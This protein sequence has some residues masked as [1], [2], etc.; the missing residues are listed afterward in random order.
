MQTDR[1]VLRDAAEVLSSAGLRASIVVRDLGSGRQLSIA[2]DDAYPLA[3]VVKLPLALAVL[4]CIDEGRLDPARP[5]TLRPDDRT[6]GLVGYCRFQHPT[7]VSVEDLLYMA[8]CLSDDT[9]ADA[10]FDLCPP[11]AVTAS[12]R[13]TGIAGITV[14]HSIRE[15][16]RTLAS[17]LPPEQMPQALALAIRAS[18]RGGGH[19]IPQLDVSSANAGTANACVE[20]LDRIWRSPALDGQKDRLRSLLAMNVVRQRLAPDLESDDAVWH[21]KTGTFLHLRHEIG[22]LEHADGRAIAIAV[23]SESSVP[24]QRQPA[25]EQALGLA[26]KLLHDR[27]RSAAA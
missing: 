21:S 17:V 2:A 19:L 5:V 11:A 14:R 16:H 9:A 15:L 26:A 8:V 3:S 23:L 1:A 12:L 7:T 20:L 6:P 10:L 25:A 13:E 22:V 4:Q 18:T 27:V 24:A